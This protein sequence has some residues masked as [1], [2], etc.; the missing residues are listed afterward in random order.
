MGS[1]LIMDT[2]ALLKG[3]EHFYEKLLVLFWVLKRIKGDEMYRL[4]HR[5]PARQKC[6]IFFSL[7]FVKK[8]IPLL[9]LVD[10]KGNIIL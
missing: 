4:H 8:N 3:V 1:G 9:Y 6:Y 10:I 5:Y 7:I 2:Q